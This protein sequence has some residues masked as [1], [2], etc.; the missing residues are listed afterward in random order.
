[1]I[2]K[3]LKRILLGIGILIMLGGIGGVLNG[4]HV[5]GAAVLV[6]GI[7]VTIRASKRTTSEARKRAL[8]KQP[9]SS[10]AWTQPGFE[11]A[12]PYCKT[13]LAGRKLPSRRSSF[14]CHSCREQITADPTQW[15]YPTPYLTEHQARYVGFLW[16]LDR[17]CFAKGSRDD[18]ESMRAQLRK[19]FGGDPGVRDVIWG[20]MNLSVME[21][22][23]SHAKQMAETAK[24]FSSGSK[25]DREFIREQKAF[26][27]EADELRALMEEFKECEKEHRAR[28]AIKKRR[29]PSTRS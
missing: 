7:L 6:L 2:R 14:A 15:L 25:E 24:L 19:N 3:W 9:D 10:Q 16:Q 12:C 22:G 8:P 28:S 26:N 11:P 1:M 23:E 21:C 13:S 5:P 18:Y 20:L 29:K 27:P 17:W 4:D